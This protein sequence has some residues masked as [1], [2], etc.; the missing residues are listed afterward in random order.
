[1][2]PGQELAVAAALGQG[3]FADM[4]EALRRYGDPPVSQQDE[5]QRLDPF[6]MG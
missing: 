2:D 1:M 4:H 5:N 3:A 6:V